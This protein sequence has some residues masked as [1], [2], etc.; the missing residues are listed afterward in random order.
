V[1]PEQRDETVASLLDAVGIP[2]DAARRYPGEFSGGQRQRIA[3][4]RA[5]AASP[6]AIVLDEPFASLDASSQAQIVNLLL[7]L[8]VSRQIGMLLISHDLGVIRQASDIVAVMYLGRIVEVAPT[9]DLW[10]KPLHPYTQALISAVPSVSDAGVLPEALA[11]EVPDPAHP[12][13]GCTF[14]PR[15]PFAFD[16]CRIAEPP[17]ARV[18]PGR[19]TACW[20][21]ESPETNPPVRVAA[22]PDDG[23]AAPAHDVQA[24]E[25]G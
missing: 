6:N 23:E 3:I 19:E 9:D 8:T 15:C 2:A 10:R 25:V 24:E 17:L 7:E 4:A 5:S 1:P 16:V 11:G 22:V 18:A 12:P 21:H 14:H 20:L 13:T